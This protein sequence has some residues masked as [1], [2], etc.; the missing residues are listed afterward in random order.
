MARTLSDTQLDQTQRYWDA[1]NYLVVGQIYLQENP[2]L[3]AEHIK[4][5]LLGHW[6]TS[7]ALDFIY[8]HLNRLVAV[9]EA[10]GPYLAGPGPGRTDQCP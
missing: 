1:A 10:N 7:P 2:P 4:P 3:R 5:R 8:V 9:T 6:G